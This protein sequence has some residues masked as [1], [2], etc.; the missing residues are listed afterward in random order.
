MSSNFSAS[1]HYI[2]CVCVCLYCLSVDW[3]KAPVFISHT[4]V[5][6]YPL[7]LISSQHQP[8]DDYDKSIPILLTDRYLPCGVSKQSK[9]FFLLTKMTCI[10]F[11][12]SFQDH[13]DYLFDIFL[14]TTF[15]LE[16]VPLQVDKDFFALTSWS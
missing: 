16:L 13:F 10:I 11:A 4:G 5:K 2:V 6:I 9:L 12:F 7:P 1:L 14:A 3:W 8:A 15:A